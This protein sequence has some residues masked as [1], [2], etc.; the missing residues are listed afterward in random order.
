MLRFAHQ[1]HPPSYYAATANAWE[2]QPPLL[3][4]ASC[5]VCVV[6]GGLAG[7]SAALNLR[8]MGFSVIVLEGSQVGFG[9]SGRSG[10]QVIAGFAS[11]IASIRA[12]VGDEAA[13]A[14]WDMSVEAVDIIDERVRR[15][16][17]RCD[18]RRGYVSVA[19]KPRHMR[20]LED[21][22]REAEQRYGYAGQQLWDRDTLRGK[23]A[24]E[25]YQGGLY[26]PRSGH[27]HS[28]NY[29]LGLARAALDAGVA[30]HEQ[31]PA[32]R[33]EHGAMPTV[34][35]E[36]GAVRCRQ[37]VLACN[38]YIGALEP[39]LERRIMPAGTYVIAT[40][41]LGEAR[42]A[43]L[44]ADAMAVC[45]TNFVLD[46]YRLSADHRLLFG[47]KVSYSGHE[48]RD[49]A[50]A[51]RR[52]M[53]RVF[54][55]LADV[56]VDYAWGGFCDITVNRAPDFGRLSGNVYYLQGFSG[57]GVNITGLAGKVVAEAIAGTASRLDLF[58]K[59]RHR[60]FPGGKLLRTPALVLGMAYYRMRD[61]L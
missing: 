7:L 59:I 47:G 29:T 25:R 49:L 3:G 8:E 17:I 35:A 36:R 28:L 31:S 20:E 44:I 57:H 34:H 50:G 38:S 27:L 15:H 37:L 53:L 55:Q 18:W 19:V 2:A 11:D 54:P 1:P 24:S 10:G 41:P 39:A 48:P 60:D 33:I 16:D 32:L 56:G 4:E 14:L 6:G 43:A 12:Q 51:M 9:A 61:Y 23:L 52:D 21:W 13:R 46:Y 22:Q 45:D 42:A 5:D 26:D 40:E 58:S 30:I